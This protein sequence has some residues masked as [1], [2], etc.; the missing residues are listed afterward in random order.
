MAFGVQKA[1]AV[2]VWIVS[3]MSV[4][5]TNILFSVHFIMGDYTTP[6]T[7]FNIF[8]NVLPNFIF[9]ENFFKDCV[10]LFLG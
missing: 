9:V 10:V 3:T 6:F 8:G 1:S 4:P 5:L 7:I 2:L